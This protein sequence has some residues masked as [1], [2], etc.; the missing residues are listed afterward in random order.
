M[1]VTLQRLKKEFSQSEA[2]RKV[3]LSALATVLALMGNPQNLL[4]F[5]HVAGTN[6][7]GSTLRDACCDYEMCRVSNRLVY[8]A[9]YSIVHRENSGEF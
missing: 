9:A 3:R 7:K 4:E 1:S 6:G 8:L 5:I 2:N